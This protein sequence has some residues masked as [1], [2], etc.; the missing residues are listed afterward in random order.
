MY[1]RAPE[2]LNTNFSAIKTKY[3]NDYNN[4]ISLWTVYWTQGNVATRLEAGDP[5]V[6]AQ[7]WPTTT[8]NSMTSFYFNRTRPICNMVSGYQRRNRKSTIV[9]P[10]ENG[11]Q[12]TADQLTKL[13]LQ[14]YKK[15]NIYEKISEA[16]HQ[17]PC[18]TGMNLLHIYL[19]FTDDPVNG[20]IK[21]DNLP[22][23]E[24]MIDPYFRQPD[25]SDANFIIRRTFLTHAAAAAIMPPEKYDAIMALQGNPNGM[26]RDG[27]FPY[28][29]ESYGYTQANRVTYDEYYYRDY[30]KKTLLIDKISGESIDVSYEDPEKVRTFLSNPINARVMKQEQTVPT[31]RMAVI[32]QDDV[33]YDGPNPL[34]I[35]VMPFV[36]VIGYYS[37][38]MPYMYSR[39]SGIVRSL[40]DPQVLLNRKIILNM[41]IQESLAN[42]GWIFKENAVVD[43]KHLF[44]TGQGRI[45][46]LKKDA[47]ISDIQQ[48]TPPQIPPS[49]FDQLA[50]MDKELYN[51]AG[52]SE[53]NLGKVV[54]DD[55]SGFQTAMRTAA[56]LTSLQ[57]IFDRL[58]LSQNMLGNIAMKVIQNNYTPMKVKRLLEGEEPSPQFYNKLFGKYH[59]VVE[60][61]FNTET[62]K[63]MEFAQLLELKKI[64]VQITDED[65]LQCATIQHKDRLIQNMQAKQQQAMQA[66]AG[67]AQAQQQL[68]AAQAQLAQARSMADMGLYAERTSRVEENRALAIQKLH[69]ANKD[70][71]VANLNKV[72]AIK[73]LETMDLN[74]LEKLLNLVQVLKAGESV[75]AQREQPVRG[76]NLAFPRGEVQRGS[77]Q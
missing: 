68:M 28:A 12:V 1:L 29:P 75:D 69:E 11:D 6:M 62:Q 30:R 18:I 53:E 37:K 33:F 35:D 39:I 15:E 60:L 58:D 65:L 43:V 3:V 34:N 27:R 57:P 77:T 25:L 36:P 70:D 8:A 19:D 46:P 16:F 38:S 45:I 59:C 67:Q 76:R 74:H 54:A 49:Y 7:L 52:I 56:G 20:D 50:V 4:N 17:G 55:A 14:I 51:C 9:V 2:T 23:N 72:K 26:G 64:G 32:I 63:Q 10:L 13:M 42:T 41:D 5:T 24:Y 61:G 31:V 48:L 47:N 73:E 21:V 44:L 71:E 40:Q 66:Q 22:F